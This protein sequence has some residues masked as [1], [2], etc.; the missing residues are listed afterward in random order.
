[1][2]N[3][4]GRIEPVVI[5]VCLYFVMVRAKG[6]AQG[7]ISYGITGGGFCGLVEFYS[8]PHRTSGGGGEG[9]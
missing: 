5:F 6:G 4:A 3:R 7:S 9:I 8:R 2:G 1:M